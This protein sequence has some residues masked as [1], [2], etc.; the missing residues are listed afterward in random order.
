MSDQ[1]EGVEGDVESPDSQKISVLVR[2]GEKPF[3]SVECP[4]C[5]KAAAWQGVPFYRA[6]GHLFITYACVEDDG[7]GSV[8]SR[9]LRESQE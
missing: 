5:G 4:R 2:K 6:G 3:P 7:C 1:S 8:G 9:P